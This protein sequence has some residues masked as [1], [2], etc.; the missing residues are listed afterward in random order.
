MTSSLPVIIRANLSADEQLRNI[1]HK[2]ALIEQLA[3]NNDHN[4]N[5]HEVSK[6]KLPRTSWKLSQNGHKETGFESAKQQREQRDSSDQYELISQLDLMQRQMIAHI[7]RLQ[8][9]VQHT[10]R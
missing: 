3:K 8:Q 4:N 6:D 10:E 5:F 9:L 7:G 1:R 2:L